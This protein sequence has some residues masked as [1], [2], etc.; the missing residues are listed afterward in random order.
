MRTF[1]VTRV[2]RFEAAHFLP[3][4]D[5]ACSQVH[6][7]SYVAH[8]TVRGD[9]L[10][11]SGPDAGMLIDMGLLG[12]FFRD[13]V[14]PSLD[15][16]LLNDTLPLDYHPVTAENIAAW[17]FDQFQTEFSVA[18]VTVWETHNQAATVRA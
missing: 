2:C 4:Y 17:I 3:D 10:Q 14:E 18:S 7:H 15:H 16:R 6:G 11:A 9:R 5:G 1:E 12:E 8:V 13:H